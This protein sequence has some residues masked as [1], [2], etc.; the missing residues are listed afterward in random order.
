MDLTLDYIS[1]RNFLIA[2]FIGALVGMEREK[3]KAREG[4]EGAG[5]RTLIL[6]AAAGAVSA[7]LS[8][9][10]SFPW[11]FVGALLGVAVLILAGYALPKREVP[12]DYG[13]TTEFASL[14]VFLLGGMTLFGYPEVAVALGIVTSVVL[15]YKKPMHSLVAKVGPEDVYAILKL[16]A[17]T[18]IVLPLLPNHTVDP[19]GA[20]NP[21]SLWWLVILIS[22]LSLVGYVAVRWLG[23]QRGIT[24]TGLAGGL[25]SSTAVTLT[26]AKRGREEGDKRSGGALAA[27]I[28]LAW[29]VMFVRVVVEVAIVYPPLVRQVVYSFAAMA[30]AA[31]AAAALAYRGSTDK[32]RSGSGDLGEDL[33][34]KNPFS[35]TAAIRFALLFAL[36]LVVV[37][38]A[39]RYFPPEGMYGVAALAGITDV[40]A[41]TLSMAKLARE[42]GSHPLAVTSIVIASLVN[43]A[44][45]AGIV[46]A[47][48]V[49]AARTKVIIGSAAIFLAGI[50]SLLIF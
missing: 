40:D 8:L 46:A 35:L 24:F 42:G 4:S 26:F 20:L 29:A 28:L 38:L 19:L 3:K 22:A 5:I 33:K 37:K 43:T 6:I 2:L 11:I 23:P 12:A 14:V 47:I 39:Q 34:L 18:F 21:Y 13:L 41:I 1:F 30:V 27:G 36:I 48:A 10:L 16:L 17:A 9:K 44:V 15:A 49:G 45:K 7:W 32:P 31:L 25:V 50:L